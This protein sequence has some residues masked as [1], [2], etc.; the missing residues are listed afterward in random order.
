MYSFLFDFNILDQFKF[1]L[2]DKT[3]SGESSETLE[4]YKLQ[5]TRDK[6]LVLFKQFSLTVYFILTAYNIKRNVEMKTIL[7]VP[8][9]TKHI[10]YSF[11]FNGS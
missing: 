8:G 5:K 3:D 9:E 4:Q 7:L 11:Y 1:L 6:I 2:E 10:T